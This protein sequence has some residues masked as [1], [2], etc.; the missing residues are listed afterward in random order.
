MNVIK[1]HIPSVSIS[2]K[3]SEIQQVV[4]EDETVI[5]NISSLSESISIESATDA[6]KIYNIFTY[7]MASASTGYDIFEIDTRTSQLQVKGYLLRDFIS[8]H[9]QFPGI[10]N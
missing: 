7:A 10:T 4:L 6:V 9:C 2:F 5:L 8:T 3:A 1:L